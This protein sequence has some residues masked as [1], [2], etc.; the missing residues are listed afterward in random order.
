MQL[1]GDEPRAPWYLNPDV[2]AP[3]VLVL[4][5]VL[6]FS[7]P[8]FSSKNFYFRDI[9]NFHYPLRKV[10]IDSYARGEFPLWNPYIYFGQPMLA[11]PNYMAFYPSNLFHLFLPF[12]YA[13]KLHFIV[14]PILAGVGIYFLQRRLGL[15]ALACFGGSVVYEF[16]GVVLSFLNLYNFVPSVALLP[17]IGWSFL[18]AMQTRSRRRIIFFA[19]MLALQVLSLDV[20]IALSDALLITAIF[21]VHLFSQP[22]P[23]RFQMLKVALRVGSL[24]VLLALGL[25]AVQIL[26]TYELIPRAVRGSGYDFNV[27]T[28]WS[29]HPMDLINVVVPNLFGNPY[30]LGL[31]G[32]WGEVYHS[33]REGYLVSFFL[34]TGA[35]LLVLLSFFG[36]QKKIQIVFVLLALLSGFLALGRFNPVS[37]WL[38]QHTPIFHLGRYPVKFTLLSVLSF[39]LLVSMGLEVL[40]DALQKGRERARLVMAFG[41]ACLILGA[42]IWVF[43]S[44]FGG[45]ARFFEEFVRTRMLPG[46]SAVKN[47][48]V[49]SGELAASVRSSSAFAVIVGLISLFSFA[50]KRVFLTGALAIFALCA[51]VLPQNLR[52]VPLLSD[53]D[54]N[55]VS[56]VN[57]SLSRSEMSQPF[58]VMALENLEPNLKYNLFA[59]NDSIAWSSLFFRKAGL[60]FYGIMNGIQYALYIPADGLNTG[61][62]NALFKAFLQR[63]S[64]ANPMI[65]QRTNTR[66]ALTLGRTANPAA[67]LE[68]TYETGSDYRLNAYRIEGALDRAYFVPGAKSVGSP[69]EALRSFLDPSFPIHTAAI[70]ENGERPLLEGLQGT[71]VVKLIRYANQSVSYETDCGEAGYLVLLDSY[72]PGWIGY[73]DGQRTPVLRAN[74]AFRAIKIPAGRH[75]VDFNYRPMYFYLGLG[76]TL[77]TLTAVAAVLGLVPL[78]IGFFQREGRAGE[79]P[80]NKN[81]AV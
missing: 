23:E 30:T 48:P 3:V 8:L 55:F 62:S 76:I 61:E 44:P 22:A 28:A 49:L 37:G 69:A 56:E 40:L 71:A 12:N 66:Y 16:S 60:P 70:I 77:A 50:Q 74:Y 51:E 20:F 80:S 19:V 24:G 42:C 36:R 67:R 39:S 10:L 27:V 57:A 46:L 75:K 43:A 1:A 38:Y 41:F 72:Y 34:G 2:I 58:R 47:L 63:G 7:D 15:P 13:F 73:L 64:F 14:H 25:A 11:N 45:H 29:L 59:P 52:L 9:L 79:A 5:G 31:K 78:R 53:A 35:S 54:V 65:L 6:F 32:Y 33:G 17:W 81:G 4:L 18:A 68:R 26:P 21:L